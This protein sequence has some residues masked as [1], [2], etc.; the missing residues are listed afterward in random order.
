MF[1]MKKREKSHLYTFLD[2]KMRNIPDL[3][4]AVK[5]CVTL[6][7]LPVLLLPFELVIFL[8]LGPDINMNG[9]YQVTF[10]ISVFFIISFFYLVWKSLFYPIYIYY[11]K[12]YC[13][14][15][16]CLGSL[17]FMFWT[18]F[19]YLN[20][21]FAFTLSLMVVS[22]LI[23]IAKKHNPPF[24]PKVIIQFYTQNDIIDKDGHAE[25]NQ[26]GSNSFFIYNL[27]IMHK[28]VSPSEKIHIIGI[29][30]SV[31]VGTPFFSHLK[32]IGSSYIFLIFLT[33]FI[34]FSATLCFYWIALVYIT[35]KIRELR[36]LEK[37]LGHRIK[38]K[39]K[40]L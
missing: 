37:K 27:D 1:Q 23:Y 25:L 26:L 5:D 28:G 39:S 14:L 3:D 22:I 40:I 9:F 2:C 16:F 8:D 10:Y 29:V 34:G 7:L 21:I 6:I 19:Y 4:K 12:I 11:S 38:Y 36:I 31:T 15:F 18:W 24:D 20:T 33:V 30:L 13:I 17:F 35:P 32:N